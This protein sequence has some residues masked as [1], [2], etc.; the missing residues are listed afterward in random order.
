MRTQTFISSMVGVA[1]AVAVA[2]SAA[3]AGLTWHGY[4]YDQQQA[5]RSLI[6][7]S[8]GTF[9]SESA[10]DDAAYGAATFTNAAYPGSSVT[11]SG[12][13]LSGP[14]ENS[15]SVTGTTTSFGEYAS[16]STAGFYFTVTGSQQVTIATG[17]YAQWSLYGGPDYD[18]LSLIG[19]LPNSS[20]ANSQTFD[21]SAGEYWFYGDA[22]A[23]SGYSGLMMSFTVP[24]PG[25]A[26]LV[27]L[28]GLVATRRRRN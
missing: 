27:G 20:P 24:A 5:Q 17:Q 28:A 15:W 3:Q 22:T 8:F 21:L 10:D 14:N 2:G 4:T 11:F 26:A 9:A 18:S 1:A 19:E 6:V 12:L 23:G 7:G 16:F 13:T 25:A